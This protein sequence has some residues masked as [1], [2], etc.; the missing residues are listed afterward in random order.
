LSLIE[1]IRPEKA[2]ARGYP[3]QRSFHLSL[4]IE[5]PYKTG[6]ISMERF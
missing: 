2:A 4:F 5:I 3:E 6:R 1:D